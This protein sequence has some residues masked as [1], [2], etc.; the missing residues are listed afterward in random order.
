M[1]LSHAEAQ[2]VMIAAQGLS[3]RPSRVAGKRDVLQTIRRMSVLQI[4]TIQIVARSP[5]LVLWSRLGDFEPAWLDELLAEGKIFEYWSHEACFLPIEDYPLYR[6]RM[7]D[8]KDMGWK[9]SHEWI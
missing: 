2:A 5:Y 1:K 9:Y 8:A 4:D 3:R 7:I 6:R